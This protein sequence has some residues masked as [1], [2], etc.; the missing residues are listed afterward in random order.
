VKVSVILTLCALLSAC[1]SG[2]FQPDGARDVATMLA[3]YEHV[4]GLTADEQRREFSAALSAHE[5]L[6]SEHTR[7]G[8]AL[9]YL[10]PRAPWRDDKRVLSLL[11][12]VEPGNA[13]HHSARYNFAQALIRLVGE[14]QRLER[15]DQ[16]KLEQLN[17]QVREER[18][19]AEEARTKSDEA[20]KK[21]DS[22]RAI[23][24]DLRQRRKEP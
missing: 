21:L 22:L 18:R 7:L 16:R 4:A 24:R 17:Q 12:R 6:A 2:P 20:I 15:E 23:D 14:R 9:M 19:K 1:A 5:K 8:L 13:E 10:L 11:E 3:S